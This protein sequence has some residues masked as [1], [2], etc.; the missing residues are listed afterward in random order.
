MDAARED[1]IER[2]FEEASAMV[3]EQRAAFLRG[4]C[5]GD[6]ELRSELEALL[7]DA[8]EA[9]DFIDRVAGPAVVRCSSVVLGHSRSAV[10]D[11]AVPRIGDDVGHF[12]VLE[13]L[14]GGGMGV[15]YKALDV[16]LG[17]TVALKFLPSHPDAGDE[18]KQRFV[19]EAKAASALDHPNICAV[20]EIGE[21]DAGQLFIAMAYYEGLTL[22]QLIARGPLALGETLAYVAQVAEGLRRAHEA[23]I[24]HRDIKPANVIVT[25]G[26]Q[27]KIV[28]FGL[29]KMSGADLTREPRAMGTI[30]Y[31]SPEQTFGSDVDAR[32]DIWSLGVLLYEMLTG[33]RPFRAEREGRLIYAIRHDDPTPIRDVRAEIPDTVAAVVSRCLDKGLV[34]RYQSADEL[35]ADLRAVEK[36]GLITERPVRPRRRLLYLG[37]AALVSVLMVLGGMLFSR[38]RARAQ[39][40]IGIRSLAVLPVTDFTGDSTREPFADEMTDLLINQLSQL[41]GLR[42]VVARTSVTQYKGTQKSS[43]AIGRELGVDGLVEATVLREGERVRVNVNLIAADAERVL[44]SQSFERPM[45][46]VLA[47]QREVAQAISREIQLQLTPQ[48]A[49]RFS[50]AARPVNPEA[51][52]LYL[53]ALR[54]PNDTRYVDQKKTYLEQSIATD[55]TFAL[56]YTRLALV[57]IMNTRDKPRAEWAIAKAL[58]LDPNLSPAYDALG[59]MRMWTDW[60][61]PAAEVAL[62]RSIALNPNNGRAHHE[63][64]QLFMRVGRCDEAIPEERRAMVSEPGSAQ[65]QSGIAEIYMNCR[66]YDDALREFQKVLEL[67]S[68]SGNV[69]WNMG[70]TYF[71]QGQYRTALAMYEK[72]PHSP[73]PGWAYVPL[74]SRKQALRQISAMRAAWARGESKSWSPWMLARLYTSLG[75]PAEALTWLERAYESRNGMVVYLKVDPHFDALRGEPRF[76][77]VL[78]KVGLDN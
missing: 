61:W 25:G 37:G 34:T 17:R 1:R 75:E 26:G 7:T 78:K 6:L 15:V 18:A 69:Y 60:D 70:E 48:E 11:G 27:V 46:D 47:L 14:G 19:Q 31:M 50:A 5:V 73:P 39:I 71:H 9:S 42:R 54:L 64:A 58:A 41:S 38:S 62:R 52:A 10:D 67:K 28:D 29:A 21:T 53:R 2:L 33:Q 77:A 74:G 32:T 45:R 72:M 43:R 22:K 36:G 40:E 76:Q 35:L 63:L 3:P 65:Y 13:K 59:L 30:A 23:G 4:A 16:R 12:R 24:I 51:F 68:D 57:Y 66:R 8:A 44:W 20:Y 49:A 56:A 55:S